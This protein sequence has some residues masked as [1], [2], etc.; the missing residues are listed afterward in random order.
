MNV[1]IFIPNTVI[2]APNPGTASGTA[3]GTGHPGPVLQLHT[4][5]GR[6]C[7]ITLLSPGKGISYRVIQMFEKSSS[8][9][10]TG[11]PLNLQYTPFLAIHSIW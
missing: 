2:V 1:S 8:F 3:S 6:N 10:D 9:G 11:P 4:S 7:E 5:I